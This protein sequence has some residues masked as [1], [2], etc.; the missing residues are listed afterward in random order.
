[1]NSL[2]IKIHNT[3][4]KWHTTWWQLKD[5]GDGYGCWQEACDNNYVQ[6]FSSQMPNVE[7][8]T[9]RVVV[10]GMWGNEWFNQT[11]HIHGWVQWISISLP[12]RTHLKKKKKKILYVSIPTVGRR[13]VPTDEKRFS[14]SSHYEHEQSTNCQKQDEF[15]TIFTFIYLPAA[16]IHT[17]R[18]DLHPLVMYLKW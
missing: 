4:A 2:F 3:S 14:L 7:P 11:V 15:K 16:F 10:G 13:L 18:T 12:S 6:L 1:M 17:R 8:K 5:H 9:K